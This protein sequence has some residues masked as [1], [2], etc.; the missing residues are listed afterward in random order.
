VSGLKTQVCHVY[1]RVGG[2]TFFFT[3]WIIKL[4]I[5]ILSIIKESNKRYFLRAYNRTSI[6]PRINTQNENKHI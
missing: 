2:Q 6:I 3:A 4:V 1:W 5:K